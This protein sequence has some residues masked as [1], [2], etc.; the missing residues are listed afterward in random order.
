MKFKKSSKKYSLY[1]LILLGIFVSNSVVRAVFLKSGE[2]NF[3]YQKLE[4]VDEQEMDMEKEID[5]AKEIEALKE[6]ARQ[7][8]NFDKFEKDA[9]PVIE[10]LTDANKLFIYINTI[11]D[12]Y[13]LD[14]QIPT[15][16][17]DVLT[18][19]K[20]VKHFNHRYQIVKNDPEK[21]ERKKQKFEVCEFI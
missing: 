9:L 14:S 19:E 4:K 21:S 15:F 12:I 16:F 17:K 18:F 20:F 6:E 10:T 1:F 11:G 8:G 5:I 3:A 7:I 2:E 13:K